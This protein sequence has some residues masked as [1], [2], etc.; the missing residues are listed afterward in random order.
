MKC[1][2]KDRYLNQCRLKVC[3]DTSYCKNHQYMIEYSDAQRE[4][5]VIC[6]GCKKAVYLEN[7]TRCDKCVNR[8]KA[9]CTENELVKTKCAHESCNSKRSSEND[10]CMKHQLHVWVNNVIAS[11]EVP[12]SM[13]KRG[14][15]NTLPKESDFKRCDECRK[16]EREKYVQGRENTRVKNVANENP[17]MKTC[18]TCGKT[19]PNKEFEGERNTTTLTCIFC[20]QRSKIQDSKRNKEH[21]REMG[22]IYD[23]KPE[24]RIRNKEWKKENWEKVTKI[25]KN[26][27]ARQREK[28]EK[29]YLHKNSEYAKQWRMKNP[30]AVQAQYEKTKESRQRQYSIYIQS[31]K[32]RNI[33]FSFDFDTYCTIVD[34]P[35]HYCGD[36]NEK[37]G[38]HGIDRKDSQRGYCL[39][40]CIACCSMCNYMKN[41]LTEITFLNRVETILTFNEMIENGQQYPDS[42]KNYNS[43]GTSFKTYFQNANKKNIHFELTSDFFNTMIQEKCYLCGKENTNGHCNGVDRVNSKLGYTIEN[44][45]A[46]CGNCNYMK[47]HYSL[48]S[49][50]TQLLKIYNNRILKSMTESEI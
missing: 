35:C 11:N 42:F 32:F 22:R 20:R 28:D 4:Q 47:N 2:G 40:N 6:S 21:R 46:C 5:L 30:K 16:K 37:R 24:R 25:W 9:I 29:A 10:Y 12:C 34:N 43:H 23:S 39:E 3:N 18:T 48:E 41:S 26:Y 7:K 36:M 15:R 27:R 1:A 50:K 19:Q 8:K 38:F 14:C 13:Y 44:T 17:E 49:Y 45:R 31:A 33:E